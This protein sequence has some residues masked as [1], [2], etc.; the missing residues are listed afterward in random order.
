MAEKVIEPKVH[1]T[2]LLDVFALAASKTATERLSAPVIGNGTL[3]SGGIKAVIGSL[4]YNKAGKMGNIVS[5]GLIIDGFE[6]GVTALM[7]RF[8]GNA[9]MG[10]NW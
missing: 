6:D 3:M 9:D 4:G 2:G 1:A 10:A 8:G 5:S 7:K